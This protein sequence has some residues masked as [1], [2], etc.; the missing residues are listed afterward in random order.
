MYKIR[1]EFRLMKLM[2]MSKEK[3][4]P[5][6]EW[7]KFIIC[8]ALTRCSLYIS[9]PNCM[10][11]VERRCFLF[12]EFKIDDKMKRH[13][14]SW[15]NNT[16]IECSLFVIELQQCINKINEDHI[17]TLNML[18]DNATCLQHKCRYF[19]WFRLLNVLKKKSEEKKR[20]T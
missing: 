13:R 1:C 18:T 8:Y 12:W 20:M 14:W 4:L 6:N 15:K 5:A 10:Y 7:I 9:F 19:F 16:W 17:Y 3:K 11:R 2:S